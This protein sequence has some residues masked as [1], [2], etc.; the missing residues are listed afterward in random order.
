M[1]SLALRGVQGARRH[2]VGRRCAGRARGDEQDAHRPAVTDPLS[3]GRGTAN[4]YES[5]GAVAPC[6]VA[7]MASPIARTPR[8]R[9]RSSS[10]WATVR[11]C[12]WSFLGAVIDRPAAIAAS[13]GI[14][15]ESRRVQ[16]GAAVLLLSVE[17]QLAAASRDARLRFEEKRRWTRRRC[18][19]AWGGEVAMQ[20]SGLALRGLE[21]R[22]ASVHAMSLSKRRRG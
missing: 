9:I 13:R 20:R 1:D 12:C 14:R 5:R 16:V 7:A 15:G 18:S 8:N 11:R 22:S 19:V 6:S 3:G 10:R 2:L 21:R 17:A 4:A